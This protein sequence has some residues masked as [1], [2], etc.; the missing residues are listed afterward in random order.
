MTGVQTCALPIYIVLKTSDK[1]KASQ[2]LKDKVHLEF[3]VVNSDNEI[4]IFSHE[5]DV[6]RI[7]KE[8]TLADVDVDEIYYARQNLEEYFTQLVK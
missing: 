1:E 5:Q 4:H 6:K 2:I 3:K 7:L 8:L